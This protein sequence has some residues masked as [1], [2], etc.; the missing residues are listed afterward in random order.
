MNMIK[1]LCLLCL[2]LLA[3]QHS[4]TLA[5]EDVHCTLMNAEMDKCL[6]QSNTRSYSLNPEGVLIRDKDNKKIIFT[7]PENNYIEAIQYKAFDKKIIFTFSIS[8]GDSG[9]TIISL[10]DEEQ[11]NYIWH[12]ELSAFNT[13]PVLIHSDSIYL[14]GIGMIARLKLSDGTIVWRHTGLYE[15]KTQAYNAFELPAIKNEYVIFREQ[16]VPDASYPGTREIHV[17]DKTGKIIKK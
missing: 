1:Q 8:D 14:G 16:K 2:T 4:L 12:T 11:F 5:D 6:I 3:S 10:F 9:S 7:P 17:L 15:A 13:S